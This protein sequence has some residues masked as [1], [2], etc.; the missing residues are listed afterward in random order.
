[1]EVVLVHGSVVLKHCALQSA[2]APIPHFPPGL[3]LDLHADQLV[4]VHSVSGKLT[5]AKSALY[6]LLVLLF[7]FRD[8][9]G[10]ILI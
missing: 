3:V 9:E 1:M 4:S 6:S 7:L 8:G 5:L 2:L 10:S